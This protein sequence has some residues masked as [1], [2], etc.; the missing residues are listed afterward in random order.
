[1]L[2]ATEPAYNANTTIEDSRLRPPL[3]RI[4]QSSVYAPLC[5]NMSWKSTYFGIERSRVKVT[6]HENVAGVNLCTL[7]SA[8]YFWFDS[9][10]N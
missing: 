7:V 10:S 8:G 3:V 1:V 6:S 9:F 2:N 4:D 5:E